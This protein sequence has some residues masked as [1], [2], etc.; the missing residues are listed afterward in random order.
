MAA[1]GLVPDAIV[2][3]IIGERLECENARVGM[4]FDGYPRTRAQAE[5]LDLLLAQNGRKV[6]YVVEREVTRMRSSNGSS[7]ASPAQVVARV[8]TTPSSVS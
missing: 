2:S 1:G 4:I 3:G 5:A 8:I 7:A 6:D